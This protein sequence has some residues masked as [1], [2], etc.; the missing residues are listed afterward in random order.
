[1]SD[2]ST[3]VR[4]D[5]AG[6]APARGAIAVVGVGNL[7]MGDD[8]VG[9]AVIRELGKERLPARGATGAGSASFGCRLRASGRFQSGCDLN[10]SPYEGIVRLHDQM[11]TAVA[12]LDR[13]FGLEII[14]IDDIVDVCI[15]DRRTL[16]NRCPRLDGDRL[17]C[18]A[19]D[20]DVEFREIRVC[21]LR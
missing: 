4:N 21:A 8:G 18:Y 3:S 11:L 14:L 12:G 7:L 10:F 5:R 2:L 15:A 16:V 17:V 19:L 1:M 20:A 9:I 13:E 6:A